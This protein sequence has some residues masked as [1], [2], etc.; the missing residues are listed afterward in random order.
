VGLGQRVRAFVLDRVLRR[1]HE[2]RT[3][4]LVGDA[5]DGDLVLLHAFEQR[6]LRLRRRA[7]DLVD[8]Q[9]VREDRP[10]AELELVFLLVEDVHAR[11]VRRQQVRG[12]LE[13]RERAVDRAGE[14][15]GQH[16]LPDPGE[17][18]DDQVPLGDDA[19]DD[20]AQR[21]RGGADDEG[22]VLDDPAHGVCA[23]D[24]LSLRADCLVHL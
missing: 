9:E 20:E 8:E 10:G 19:E 11:D 6:G 23:D 1:H 7:V 24:L 13:P 21:L 3:R 17:V 15:L 4:Q 14:R 22:D 12:E 16:R 2:E 5:V 18:L